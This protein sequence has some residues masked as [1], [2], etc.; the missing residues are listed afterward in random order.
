MT[1]LIKEGAKPL[2][3]GCRISYTVRC[4]ELL[5]PSHLPIAYP[6]SRVFIIEVTK[7]LKD[8]LTYRRFGR[9]LFKGSRFL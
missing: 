7:E 1:H 5:L 2:F 9:E 4:K 8:L 6:F 3:P